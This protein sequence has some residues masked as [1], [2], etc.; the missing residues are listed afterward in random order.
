MS[1]PFAHLHVHSHYSPLDGIVTPDRLLARAKELGQDAMAITDHGVMYGAVDFYAAAKKIGV[2]PLIGFEAYV[3]PGDRREKSPAT[4]YAYNHLTLLARNFEGYQNLSRLCSEGFLSGFYRYPRIDKEILK[5]WSGGVACLSGCLRG[6]IPQLILSGKPEEAE[7]AARW[8]RD[9]FGDGNFFLEIMQNGL[10]DQKRL[11]D[12]MR[13][14][15][16]RTGIPLVATA[17][18]HYLLPEDMAIQDIMICITTGKLLTDEKRM[19]AEAGCHL[20]SADEMLAALPGFEDAVENTRRV[21]DICG[22]ELPLKGFHLPRLEIP[23][24]LAAEEYLSR[25]CL[26]GLRQRYG[27]PLP[28]EVR[29]RF[30]HELSVITKMGFP[31][32]FLI[33]W[34][35]VN[36]ARSHGIPVGPG[37]GSAAGSIISYGLGITSLD[38][39]RYGLFF[40]RFLNEGRNEM[41]D[42]DLDFDKERRQEVVAHIIEKH[43]ARHCAKIIT[44]GCLSLKSGIRDVGRVM[45]VPLARTDRLAKLVPDVFKPDKSRTPLQSA[46]SSIPEL[47]AEYESDPETRRLLDAVGQLDGAMRNTGVHAAGVVVADRDIT[48]Y[49]PLA[50]RDGE[51]TTQYE[52]KSLEKFGLCKIDVLGLETLSLLK[53]TVDLIEKTRGVKLDIDRPPLDDRPTYDMLSRGDAKGVFQCE[54]EGFRQLLSQLKPDVFEDLIAAVAIYRPGPLQF[55]NNFVNRKHKREGITY[56]HPRM[57]PILRETYGLILYQEQVQALAQDLAHFSLSEGDL[58]RRAMGKKDA[59]IMAAYRDKFISQAG[60]DIGREVAEKAYDQ[61]EVFAGYGFN[62]SHSACYALIAYQTAYLKCHYPKEFM[63][64]TL[65]VSRGTTDDVVLYMGD[66]ADMGIHT[67]PVDINHSEAFFSVEGNDIRFGMAAVKGVGDQAALAVEEERKRGGPFKDLFDF[68]GRID[69]KTINKGAAEALIKSGAMDCFN[70]PRSRLVAGLESAM[71]AGAAEQKARASGQLGLFGASTAIIPP[72]VLPSVPDWTEQQKL[73]FEKAALGFY[74]TSH[75]LAEHSEKLAAFATA[76]LADL[77]RMDNGATA[78]LGGLISKISI[79]NDKKGRRFASLDF[80]DMEGKARCMV[81][82]SVY[83]EIREKLAEDRVV[84]LKAKVDKSRD[85][86]SLLVDDAIPLEEAEEKL[87]EKAFLRLRAEELEPDGGDRLP[88]LRDIVSRYPGEVSLFFNLDSPEGRVDIRAGQR[89][90]IRPSREAV[91]S[92]NALFGPGTLTLGGS[93]RRARKREA[94]KE[95]VHQPDSATSENWRRRSGRLSVGSR[96]RQCRSHAASGQ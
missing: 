6:E 16:R 40:E 56:L 45:G 11:L 33:V 15:S 89:F 80:E 10:D 26:E 62:K 52:M 84:F 57:E 25:I 68:A 63:A 20:K 73:Q 55:L 5:Q 59:K 12:P 42:I 3:A 7:K 54:S 96:Q 31:D 66:A 2:K 41:P 69:S 24:G 53:N 23:D 46:L 95:H 67:C 49:G 1:V 64:A 88:R 27:D 36:F 91:E 32:Y 34:D 75:P 86:P 85:Q 65:T 94:A 77:E 92:I 38:P 74:L 37:R 71:K 18:S 58:M 30:D 81:F 4:E 72:S 35:V 70:C 60:A 28:P 50:C 76:S 78:I 13:E 43:G 51:T 14:L 17:D 90:R 82:A 83:E 44:F 87:A 29:E 8:Y 21:A 48:D 9:I 22:L 39:L 61:I 79:K 19:R 47:R 93:R